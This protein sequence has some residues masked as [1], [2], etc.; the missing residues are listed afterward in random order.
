[1]YIPIMQLRNSEILIYQEWTGPRTPPK[2][3]GFEGKREAY[4]GVVTKAA[5]KRMK[6][7]ISLLIQK[8]PTRKIYNPVTKGRHDF[9][10]GFVTMTIADQ[11]GDDT[12]EV[13]KKC[14]AP[15]LRWAKRSG[16]N[17]YVWKAELQERGAVHYHL[18]TNVFLH[19]QDIQDTWNKY[20][21]KAGYL[22]N[23]AKQYGSYKA[24]STDVHSVRKVRD[25]ERYLTK[26]MMKEAGGTIDGKI[27][28]C[29]TNLKNAR[30][31]A[32]EMTPRNFELIRKMAVKE[33]DCDHCLIYRI[34]PD[35]GPY[36]LDSIQ[37]VEY[38]IHLKSI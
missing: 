31:F 18:A 6:K 9:R 28:D 24:N 26:Y 32:T 1:M 30:Y 5:Q 38:D 25:I 21:R 8:S 13:Y 15:W 17:D 12:K 35:S 23:Y 19:Y 4:S 7:A 16:M 36:V 34:K 22:T 20:Q 37:Q 10:I 27:W 11:R 2:T 33:I 3:L 14:L 29:S